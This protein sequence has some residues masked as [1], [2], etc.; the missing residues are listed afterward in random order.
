MAYSQ[1]SSVLSLEE[2]DDFKFFVEFVS[3]VPLGYWYRIHTINGTRNVTIEHDGTEEEAREKVID[4][5]KKEFYSFS[6]L[7]ESV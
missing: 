7:K 5:I 4:S 3:I 2:V 6:S 1:K